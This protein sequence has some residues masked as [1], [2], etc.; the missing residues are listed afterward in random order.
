MVGG[1]GARKGPQGIPSR[2]RAAPKRPQPFKS[3]DELLERALEMFRVRS[4]WREHSDFRIESKNLQTLTKQRHGWRKF[5]HASFELSGDKTSI[6]KRAKAAQLDATEREFLV[7][8]VLERLALIRIGTDCQSLLQMACCD[9]DETVMALRK[10]SEHGS[11]CRTGLVAH[12]DPDEDLCERRLLVDPTLVEVVLADGQNSSVAWSAET[13]TELYSALA[14]LIH[15]LRQRS[16]ALQMIE[17]DAY[18]G[19]HD[20]LYRASRKIDRLVA[21]LLA[22]LR[23]HP[24]WALNEFL[25]QTN[26][27]SRHDREALFPEQMI[28]LLL[29]GKELGHVST[30]DDVFSGIGLARA[31]SHTSYR[32]A[33]LLSLLSHGS[34]LRHLDLVRPSSGFVARVAESSASLASVEFELTEKA[35]KQL[36]LPSAAI[37]RRK[38]GRFELREPKIK[39][40]NLV[41]DDQVHE[42]LNMGLAQAR[43]AD[44]LFG[45]W[46]LAEL[47]PYGRGVTMLFAGPPGTGKTACAE[48]FA[49]ELKRPILVVNYAQ[50]Q[51]C[52]V[53]QTEKNISRVF[54]DAGTSSGVLFW[55]EADAM[56]FD[57]DSGASRAWE[58][59][60]INVLLQ[61]L[62]RFEGVCI[63]A[64]NRMPSLDKALERRITLKVRF[65]KPDR[66][67]REKIWERFLSTKLPLSKSVKRNELYDIELTGGEIKNVILN[68]ARKALL[69][70]GK[71]ARVTMK[72][73]HSALAFEIN[74]QWTQEHKKGFG[75]T[76]K[77]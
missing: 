34:T 18:H 6:S 11:L 47:I 4:K 49:A 20:Q 13:E 77:S 17:G 67:A 44:V 41:L 43:N 63:L 30:E 48:A 9:S 59:R 12:S 14:R 52:L 5:W 27:D 57:R 8:L 26:V 54:Q 55:D 61:E 31:V 69:R 68:A 42:A 33:T 32:S 40:E 10:L 38:Q 28:L 70:A 1:R 36:K 60:E 21:G 74:G 15:A 22:T 71:R 51:N 29:L 66:C 46:G 72:D 25:S 16:G 73:F 58:V 65:K 7:L 76:S 23:L 3:D 35:L 75:F 2:I 45:R 37:A 56:F 39:M 64:T 19:I 53:G 62:E 24:D 50:I